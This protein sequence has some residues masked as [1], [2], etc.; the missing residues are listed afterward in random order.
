MIEKERNTSLSIFIFYAS[1]FLKQLKKF[2]FVSPHSRS[3]L[4]I[5]KKTLRFINTL[6]GV[7]ELPPKCTYLVLYFYDLAP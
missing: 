4:V 2:F 1:S 6:K 7:V 3:S 5:K